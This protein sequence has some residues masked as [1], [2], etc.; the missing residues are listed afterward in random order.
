VHQKGTRSQGN[1]KFQNLF[2]LDPPKGRTPGRN[3]NKSND[4]SLKRQL[5]KFKM[6]NVSPSLKRHKKEVT[7]IN[8]SDSDEGACRGSNRMVNDDALLE[9]IAEVIGE[10]RPKSP[11]VQEA[12]LNG[13]E[14][15]NPVEHIGEQGSN[16]LLTN[17]SQ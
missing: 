7:I 14:K 2:D 15:I 8:D 12:P 17:E 1:P 10:K 6:L 4:V 9:E 13:G 3:S 5:K 11:L 16:F